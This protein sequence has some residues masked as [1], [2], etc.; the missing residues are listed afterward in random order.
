MILKAIDF[1]SI[2]QIQNTIT[3]IMPQKLRNNHPTALQKQP[4][5]KSYIIREMINVQ[6]YRESYGRKTK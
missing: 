5:Q 4:A 6:K 2:R 1:Q 3:E